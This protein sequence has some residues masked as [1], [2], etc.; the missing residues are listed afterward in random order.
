M[1]VH[2]HKVSYLLVKEVE[3]KLQSDRLHVALLQGARDVHV[4]LEEA[5]HCR[6]ELSL[7]HLEL[8]EQI[9]EPLERALVPVDPEEVHLYCK[10]EGYALLYCLRDLL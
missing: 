4:H 8:G 5:L 1:N 7:L 3:G 9:D 2:I 6:A 10:T